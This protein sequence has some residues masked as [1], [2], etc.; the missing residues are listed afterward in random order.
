M[1]SVVA[2]VD[3]LLETKEMVVHVM[4]VKGLVGYVW[5]QD[6]LGLNWLQW[7]YK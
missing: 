2:I 4:Q 3:R 6:T 5:V 1:H 7:I